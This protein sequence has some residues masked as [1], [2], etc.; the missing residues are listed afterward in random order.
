MTRRRGALEGA[1]VSPPRSFA[2]SLPFTVSRLLA[3]TEAA[4]LR[5]Y[6]RPP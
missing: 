1:V 4:P 6:L 3:P 5:N 2:A